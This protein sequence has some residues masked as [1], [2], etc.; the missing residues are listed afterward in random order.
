MTMEQ[1]L[2][3]ADAQGDMRYG[4]FGGAPGIFV[5]ASAW[6]IAGFVALYGSPQQAVITLFVGGMMIHP[7]AVLVAKAL[8]R[9]GT[10]T[11][12]N[13]LGGLALEGTIWMLLSLVLAYGL[14]L[15]RAE[16]FFPAM[17]LIIG[18]RYLTFKTIYGMWIYW[19]CGAALAAAGFLLALNPAS[20][21]IGAFVG[22]AIEFA[23][24]AI[25][26]AMVR[27]TPPA[28]VIQCDRTA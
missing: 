16:L 27:N 21:A 15:W 9:P 4:Y 19:A 13:P 7:L 17:L 20:M 23:F 28:P 12:G 10:H 22:S 5:S 25:V 1:K 14:S 6:L 11:A 26:Y 24:S 2:T 18:G 3:I 8:G